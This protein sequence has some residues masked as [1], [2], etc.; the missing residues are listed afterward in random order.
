MSIVGLSC[1]WVASASGSWP[2]DHSLVSHNKTLVIEIIPPLCG[3]W[4]TWLL[5][6]HSTIKEYLYLAIEMAIVLHL[7]VELVYA[8]IFCPSSLCLGC[9]GLPSVIWELA[10]IT[11]GY[12]LRYSSSCELASASA[13]IRNA[14]YCYK[15]MYGKSNW[16]PFMDRMWLNWKTLDP[17]HVPKFGSANTS[18]H[19]SMSIMPETG[20]LYIVFWWYSVAYTNIRSFFLRYRV[21]RINW[22][23]LSLTVQ[24]SN[25]LNGLVCYLFIT[26]KP[27]S[28][29]SSDILQNY[30]LL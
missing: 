13:F 21:T 27:Y 18:T 16:L 12:E 11:P 4:V 22:L 14:N 5:W 25:Y 17:Y 23:H 19:I 28:F 10:H 8:G 29:I 20:L 7:P 3:L 26:Q 9:T 15:E 1:Q 30:L 24:A 2:Q 6:K